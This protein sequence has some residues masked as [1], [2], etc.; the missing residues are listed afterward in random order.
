M[1]RIPGRPI[2][3]EGAS[4][5]LDCQRLCLATDVRP[6]NTTVEPPAEISIQPQVVNRLGKSPE[7]GV[8]EILPGEGRVASERLLGREIIALRGHCEQAVEMSVD[9]QQVL[10]VGTTNT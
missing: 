8:P 10:V 2:Q 5:N 4:Y 6:E 7:P 3:R 9:G 1:E